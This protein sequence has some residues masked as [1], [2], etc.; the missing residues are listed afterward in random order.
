MF[1]RAVLASAAA[2]LVAAP[3]LA[4]PAWPAKP[5]RVI[6][7]YA[8]GG[9]TDVVGRVVCQH[10][11][12][13]LGQQ[14]LV[15]NKAGAGASLGTDIVAKAAPDGHTLLVSVISGFAISPFLYPTVTYD[16]LRDF[17][18]IAIMAINPSVLVVNNTFPAKTLKEYVEY[19]R[20]SPGKL[21]FATSGAGSSN[22]L[23]GVMLQRTAG[24]QMEHVPYRGAGPAMQDT[25]AG[26]VPSMFDSL[27]S[28]SAHI[29]A[30]KIRA[31]AVSGEARNPAFPDVPTMKESGYPD[32]ISNSWF[33]LSG[34]ARLA[35]EIV[36]KVHAHVMEIMKLPSVVETWSKLGADYL[37]HSPAEV[38]AFIKAE[39]DRYKP[40][41]AVSG[42]KPD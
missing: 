26:N 30:G 23:L 9:S 7:P 21:S 36:N 17:T 34:P 32:L 18:H 27:P 41:V 14:F 25:I 38:T 11:S 8:P 12:E 4:Q 40:I 16:P 39:M 35:P 33:G 13:R 3:A 5:V 28:A 2:S 29:R 31:L 1:R 20:A 42:A 22:H 24:I 15:E 37:R 19:A 10:L 6:V